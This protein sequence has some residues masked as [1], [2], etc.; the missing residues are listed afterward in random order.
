MTVVSLR[1]A[2]VTRRSSLGGRQSTVVGRPSFFRRRSS[3][4]LRSAISRP[5]LGSEKPHSSTG[6]VVKFIDSKAL[7]QYL[8]AEPFAFTCG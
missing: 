4:P 1:S 2:V 8:F 7:I 3:V 5:L 6:S